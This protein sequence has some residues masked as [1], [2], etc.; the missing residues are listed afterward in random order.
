MCDCSCQELQ[1]EFEEQGEL[2]G[3]V[4]H[5]DEFGPMSV[6]T[7]H[8]ILFLDLDRHQSLTS[9]DD[10]SS[11][12]DSDKEFT[13]EELYLRRDFANGKVCWYGRYWKDHWAFQRNNHPVLAMLYSHPCFP[14][15]RISF[16]VIFGFNLFFTLAMS[17]LA[18]HQ[19]VCVSCNLSCANQQNGS[20]YL[21]TMHTITH[22]GLNTFE[23]F[24]SNVTDSDIISWLPQHM[25]IQTAN[26]PHRFLCCLGQRL[27]MAWFIEEFWAQLPTYSL[28]A[29]VYCVLVNILYMVV[30]FQLLQC[31]PV[32][33]KG[34]K[35]RCTFEIA[36]HAVAYF[37]QFVLFVTLFPI[38]FIYLVQNQ[39]A[40]IMLF[41]VVSSKLG[42]WIGV[43]F[44]KMAL[45]HILYSMQAANDAQQRRFYV[46]AQDFQ[47]YERK[48]NR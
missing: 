40:T 30:F 3:D 17:S 15:S 10:S 45:F 46:T 21:E 28:G 25:Q 44:V 5:D 47:K 32:Q 43:F 39:L 48:T 13:E 2:V 37:L 16:Y 26:A 6:R 41:S 42:S 8:A 35:V 20:C 9:S 33:S 23:H 34:Y 24:D 31:F 14:V 4:L 18:T 7:Y 27:G 36:G 12:L 38:I 11:G 1:A 29:Q 19:Q 22:S